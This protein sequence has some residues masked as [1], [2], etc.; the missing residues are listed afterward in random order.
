M[1]LRMVAMVVRDQQCVNF[2]RLH[3]VRRETLLHLHAADPGVDQQTDAAGFHEDAVAVAAG[4][5]GHHAHGRIVPASTAEHRT[6][7]RTGAWSMHR[8]IAAAGAVLT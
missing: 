1:A 3:T 8:P 4:L 5:E 2:A 6:R 7:G